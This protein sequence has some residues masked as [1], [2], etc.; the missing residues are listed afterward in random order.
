MAEI[1]QMLEHVLCVKPDR[2]NSRKRAHW[3]T[4]PMA[5]GAFCL[6]KLKPAPECTCLDQE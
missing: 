3:S 1:R 5:N 2:N 6:N 4:V